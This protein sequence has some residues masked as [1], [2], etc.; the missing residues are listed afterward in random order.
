MIFT[1]ALVIFGIIM[2]FSA[3]YYYSISQDGTAYSYLRRQIMWVIAGFCAMVFGAAFDYR[4][5]RK[6]AIPFLILGVILLALIFTPLGHT[7]NNA[8]RWLKVEPITFMP[9][10][11]AKLFVIIFTAWFLSE[12]PDRIK[13]VTKGILPL[14]GIAAVYGLF[15]R[16]SGRNYRRQS[17]CAAEPHPCRAGCAL[18]MKRRYA[19]GTAALGGAGILS[20]LTVYERYLLVST[21]TSFVDPFQDPPGRRLSGGAVAAGS[22]VGRFIRCWSWKKREKPATAGTAERLY[23]GHHRRRT[24]VSIGIVL[25]LALYCWFLWRGVHVAMHVWPDRSACSWH[26]GIVSDGWNTSYFKYIAVVTFSSWNS[27]TGISTCHL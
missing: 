19:L 22:G 25:V 20:I 23:P 9:G 13:S 12:K 16:S 5:Y 4:R 15:D 18:A 8:T 3:S 7:A 11:F 2:V 10:E 1:A 17:Q 21:T 26:S 27:P 14:V 24:R 6:F